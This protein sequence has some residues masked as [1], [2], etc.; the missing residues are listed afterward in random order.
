MMSETSGRN[1]HQPSAAAR[2]LREQVAEDRRELAETVSD[3]HDK[4]DVKGRVRD[5][6]ADAEIALS[7]LAGRAG[8]TAGSAARFVRWAGT[9]AV[10][11][12]W[13]RT[14]APVR[15]QVERA[16][17]L[18]HRELRLVLATTVAMVAA[19]TILVRRRNGHHH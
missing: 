19:L 4:T 17:G 16:G 1:G 14:P 10:E 3:L 12:V 18:V 6:A 8:R 9:T 13:N 2:E 7:G 5:K 15:T 11:P